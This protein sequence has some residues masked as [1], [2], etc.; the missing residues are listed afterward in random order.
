MRDCTIYQLPLSV[1]THTMSRVTRS[2][3]E[4]VS[5][6]C[7]A[8]HCTMFGCMYFAVPGEKVCSF[9]QRGEAVTGT[10]E[11]T[12]HCNRFAKQADKLVQSHCVSDAEFAELLAGTDGLL[13]KFLANVAKK[14]RSLPEFS[15][16][17]VL[18]TAAQVA[19]FPIFTD[20]SL[21]YSCTFWNVSQAEATIS[22]PDKILARVLDHHN[23]GRECFVGGVRCYFGSHGDYTTPVELY[24]ARKQLLSSNPKP[25]GVMK[26]LLYA[27]RRGDAPID[28]FARLKALQIIHTFTQMSK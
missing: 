27:A 18:F 3:Q 21:Q 20:P 9:C 10:L 11:H 13:V 19:A 6:G 23:L 7:P 2:A 4:I 25:V 5:V 14:E 16:R 12:L 26:P 17:K 15:L 1:N 24:K 8:R 28:Q 22:I